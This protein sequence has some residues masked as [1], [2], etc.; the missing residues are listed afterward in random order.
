M[1]T[2]LIER[3]HNVFWW[4][5]AFEHQQKKWVADKN[6]DFQVNSNFIIRV[7]HGLGYR[8][9]ISLS[10]YIDHWIVALKFRVES[11]NEH[12]PDIIIV[13]TPCYLLAYESMR[14]AIRDGIP[15][16]VDI[17]DLWPDIFIEPLKKIGL[18]HIGRIAIFFDSWKLK[19]LLVKADALIAISGGCLSWGLKKAGRARKG[20]DRV[21]YHGYKKNKKNADK[22]FCPKYERFK[23]KKIILFVGTFGASYELKLILKAARKF[24]NDNEKGICFILA[25]TG[26]QFD[27][28]KKASFGLKNVMLSGWISNE[29]IGQLLNI[30]LAGIVPCKSVENAL[31]TKYSS[32]FLPDCR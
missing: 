19:R 23:T 25:G 11:K 32:T 13:S 17:R 22:V 27:E 18:E 8:E 6:Q 16:I 29:E 10:R 14:F 28:L 2:K 9:N 30:A 5:S 21:F 3:G 26:D 1:L 15:Y 31:L 7:L 4:A 12:K 24:Q 20:L